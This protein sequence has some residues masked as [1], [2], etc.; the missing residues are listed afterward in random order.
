MLVA[1]S[2]G[3]R[4]EA[5]DAAQL[6]EYH[7]AQCGAP[8]VPRQSKSSGVMFAHRRRSSCRWTHAESQDHQSA[9]LALR[10]AIAP[11]CL[12]TELE[13]EVPWLE[14]PLE[15]VEDLPADHGGDRRADLVVWSP[16][17][18]PIAIE[19]QHSAITVK[20]LERRA[21]SYAGAGVAQIWLPFLEAEVVAT[22]VERPSGKDG[23]W[24]IARYPAPR[25]QRWL[26]G[27]NFGQLW[28]YEGERSA[29]WCGRFSPHYATVPSDSPESN[30][31]PCDTVE[32]RRPSKR[33]RELTLWGP[34]R[35]EELRI[36]LG[37]R[38]AAEL[39]GYR[40]PAGPTARFVAPVPS[41]AV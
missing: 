5:R 3:Q 8:V 36:D 34:Y 4:V 15:S 28:F 1:I 12:R 37:Y 29:L 35:A 10:D 26:H 27:Y 32:Y 9:K 13:W 6:A 41:L 40:Y 25:W 2:D 14:R 33:W 7:C 24:V 22:A 30:D 19:L 11:R 39:G 23:N 17:N 21:F 31:A 20:H 38:A 16:A 18:R